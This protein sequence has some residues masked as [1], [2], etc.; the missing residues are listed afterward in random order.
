M[1]K[2]IKFSWQGILAIIIAVVFVLS[3]IF[4]NLIYQDLKNVEQNIFNLY[5]QVRNTNT[6]IDQFNIGSEKEAQQSMKF[7]EITK[8]WQVYQNEEFNFQMKSPASWGSLQFQLSPQKDG[9]VTANFPSY[10]DGKTVVLTFLKYNESAGKFASL[11]VRDELVKESVGE[12]S[13]NLFNQ[14]KILGKGEIRN[15]F[16]RENIL[17]QKFIV[18][19]RV[20]QVSKDKI[21]DEHLAV[22]PRNDYYLAVRLSEAIE[23]E[24][25]YF[26]QS[27]VFIN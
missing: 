23:A 10:R 3:L 5:Q 13:N 19:R 26:I 14:L 20:E 25:D 6:K 11:A 9:A 8:N 1:T 2:P 15:C 21:F 18:Y 16:V 4:G 22:F 12:C 24:V 17:K 27:I 7:S